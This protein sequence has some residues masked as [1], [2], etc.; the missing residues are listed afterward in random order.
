MA[1]FD[2][3]EQEQIAEI[4]ALWA[5]WGAL[6]S[7][8]VVAM[9]AG[10]LGRQGWA[11]YKQHQGEAAAQAYAAVEKAFTAHDAAKT[12]AAA[13]AMVSG[14]SGHALTARAMLLAAKSAYDAKDLEHA[15]SALQWVVANAKEG[16]IA[17]IASL[18]LANVL[19][20]QKQYDAAL[21]AVTTPKAEDYAGLFADA[22]GDVLAVKGDTAGARKAYQEAM[23]KLDK[24]TP[25]YQVVQT[26]LSALGA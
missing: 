12:R 16:S 21:Q 22:R 4:K 19:I 20:D 5:K 9:V 3:Q 23:T 14:E 2:L 8:T 17:D 13:E 26:K 7:L 6:I 15:K 24:Q 10:Y 25:A 1:A 18:R 11:A